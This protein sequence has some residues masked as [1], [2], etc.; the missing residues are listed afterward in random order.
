MAIG[1]GKYDDL[2]THV[3]EKTGGRAVILV[4]LGDNDITGFSIQA[5]PEFQFA[6]PDVLHTLADAIEEELKQ[7]VKESMGEK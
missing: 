7:L 1:P 5:A 2:C 3:R 4:V 6:L